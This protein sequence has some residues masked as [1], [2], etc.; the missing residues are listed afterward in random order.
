MTRCRK[1]VFF[2]PPHNK[3]RNPG[4]GGSA[5]VPMQAPRQAPNQV[6]RGRRSCAFSI[7]RDLLALNRLWLF[8]AVGS[9]ALQ[10][11]RCRA[12]MNRCSL[13][14]SHGWRWQQRFTF[15][16]RVIARPSTHVIPRFHS[17]PIIS[18]LCVRHPTPLAST[19]NHDALRLTHPG[20]VQKAALQKGGGFITSQRCGVGSGADNHRNMI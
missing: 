2:P 18:C 16:D 19:V 5:A 8:Q 10:A 11:S 1:Q 4:K 6:R 13:H 15:A 20:V 7:R 12:T 17:E 9:R 3:A 14:Y